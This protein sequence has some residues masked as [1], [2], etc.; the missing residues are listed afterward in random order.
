MKSIPSDQPIRVVRAI[1]WL[2]VGGIERRLVAV[3]PRLAALGFDIRL[4]CL[5]EFGPLAE[6]IRAAGVPVDLLK[7]KTRLHPPG[8][9]AFAAYL[10]EHRTQILHA[11]M[12]RASVPGTVAAR[13]AHT[14]VVFGQVHN[15]GTW[16]SSR[17]VWTDRFL[18][19]WR[20]G[21]IAVS[22]AV[23]RDV[24]ATLGLPEEQV[25]VLYNGIDTDHF[26]PDPQLRATARRELALDDDTVALL[27][28]A[29]LHA[30]KNPQGV[31]T[32]FEAASA[33]AP[34]RAVLLFAGKGP[35]E[36]EVRAAIAQRGLAER[37][38]LLGS[39]DDMPALYNAADA[40]VLSSFK[41]GF[42]NAVVEALAC[43]KPVI[44]ADV[45]GN[46]E[47][48]NDERVGWIHE[49]GDGE[50]LARQMAEALA[51]PAAL[52]ARAD[53]CRARALVFSLDGLVEQTATLYR[54]ALAAAER[55]AQ[56]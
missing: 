38:R 53:D 51:N 32:A 45:G 22:Q 6:E 7:M 34:H 39:R 30:N 43:G 27:V 29:R 35:L 54:Q 48:V 3:L 28:P 2:P 55:N 42:S 36:E 37:V 19:R 31:L 49:A 33:R 5:R 21:M 46:K 41:E 12:Y 50:A 25:R 23:Q 9:R 13:M 24:C 11:H 1:T 52:V 18:C 14:P 44:A 56:Q 15:V 47:A 17:Q 20:T 16:E 26:F 10:R 8:L 40:V 4:V